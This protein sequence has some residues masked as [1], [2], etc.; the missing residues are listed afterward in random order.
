MLSSGEDRIKIGHMV[1]EL[2]GLKVDPFFDLDD[3]IT[4]SRDRIFDQI[5]VPPDLETKGYQEP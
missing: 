5:I 4:R 3:V 1:H 2:K